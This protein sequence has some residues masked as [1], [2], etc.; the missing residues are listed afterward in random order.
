MSEWHC[1]IVTIEKVEKHPNADKLSIAYVNGD[2]PVII[3]NDD[4]KVGDIASYLCV[5]TVVPD[6]EDYHFLSP[7]AFEQYEEDDGTGKMI[8][9]NRPIGKKYPVGSV[10]ERYRAIKAKKTAMKDL[11]NCIVFM[12]ECHLGCTL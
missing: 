1:Q 3:K 2:Y 4:F 12:I 8:V 10:P 5:D 9:K 11:L 6:V 7:N